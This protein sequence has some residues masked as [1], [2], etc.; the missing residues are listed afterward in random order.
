MPSAADPPF[1]GRHRLLE[2][3]AQGAMGE[4]YAARDE[5]RGRSVA[6]KR[7][8]PEALKIIGA[9]EHF[10]AEYRELCR[11]EHPRIIEV[12]D[13]GID[14]DQPFY[15]M[16]LLDGED[17][18][19]LAPMPYREA[20]RCLRDVASSLA[21][22]HARRLLHRDLS[23]R[24]VRRT[25]DG[26]CKLL[27]FGTMAPFGEPHN[28]AGT[29]P[30]VPPEALE[31]EALD[32]RSDLYSLG[33]LAYW[34]LTGR[35]AHDVQVIDELPASWKKPPPR[36]RRF[37]PEIPPALDDLVLSLLEL[38]PMGRPSSA[39]EVIERLTAAGGLEVDDTLDVAAS[40]LAGARLVGREHAMANIERRIEQTRD[41]RGVAVRID[42]DAGV[43][44]SRLLREAVLMAQ[45]Q[46]MAV[47]HA[48]ARDCPDERALARQ[49]AAE[50]QGAAPNDAAEARLGLEPGLALLDSH[51]APGAP[52]TDGTE[53][54]ARA[55]N[56]VAEWF[57]RVSRQRPL[58]VAVDDL[59]RADEF[60]AAFVASLAI[61]A[62]GLPLLVLATTTRRATRDQPSAV[63]ALTTVAARVPLSSL[64]EAQTGELMRSIF[65]DVPQLQ[66]VTHW[67]FRNAHGN[68]ALC[69]ELTQHLI[70]R[71]VVRYVSGQWA[72]PDTDITEE[73]PGELREALAMRLR[74][75]SNDAQ[76]IARLVAING[77]SAPDHLLRAA[78]EL[79]ERR[80][81]EA[82]RE[83]EHEQVLRRSGE[84]WVLSLDAMREALELS[85]EE[86]ERR[87]LHARLA[88]ALLDDDDQQARLLAGWHLV[89]TVDELRGADI[90]ADLGPRL[91]REGLGAASATRAIE[92]ALEVY[93]RHG[94]P[95]AA[96]LGLRSHLIVGGYLV[97]PA[98]AH[99]YGA[100]TI[101]ALY[102]ASG[103][104][105][106]RRL[107][108]TLGAK[109]G[110]YLGAAWAS[111]RRIFVA[112]SQRPPHIV[113]AT[114]YFCR[115]T[116]ALVGVRAT[117][118]D[119]PGTRALAE[120]IL[121]L[122]RSGIPGATEVA[123]TCQ[124]LAL[125]PWGRESEL[126][127]ALS[128]A[129]E[130]LDRL[131]VALVPGMTEAD[132]LDMRVGLWLSRGI[133]A[134]YRPGREG[135]EVA[136]RVEAMG[137]QLSGVCAD[138]IRTV[139]YTVRGYREEADRY[140][141]RIEM[142]AVQ[143]GSTWQVHAFSVPIEGISAA[144]YGDVVGA[145]RALERIDE[146]AERTP[147]LQPLR[148]LC[149]SAYQYARGQYEEV[150]RLGEAW[151][152]RH[153]PGTVIGWAQA[154][155]AHAGALL[156]LGRAEEARDMAERGL[157]AVPPDDLDYF[158]M[159]MPL[160]GIYALAVGMSGDET[161]SRALL[162]RLE[163]RLRDA[164]EHSALA[165]LS[166]YRT[167]MARKRHDQA[168][169]QA[170]LQSLEEAARLSRNPA[171]IA[172]AERIAGLSA[173]MTIGSDPPTA[174]GFAP[175]RV[176]LRDVDSGLSGK[177]E[178]TIVTRVLMDCRR[179][180][181][182]A[183][184]A[185]RL[186]AQYAGASRGYLLVTDGSRPRVAASLSREQP[187]EALERHVSDLIARGRGGVQVRI[188][189]D[190][191]DD[192]ACRVFGVFLLP[193][194]DDGCVGAVALEEQGEPL[195]RVRNELLREVGA[196]LV[197]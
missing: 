156:A 112:R 65:G 27:D 163:L 188:R 17:L 44:K 81:D 117:G 187:P 162:S 194:E 146:L 4:V 181:Q 11:L 84:R 32:Q 40:Y 79:S 169:L 25:G 160:Q 151:Q 102:R 42:G 100:E 182:R 26:R 143:G 91:M 147:S 58:L 189:A 43:G 186:L 190:D 114:H 111:V 107:A 69:V 129:I 120:L 48:S 127:R 2:R 55:Q 41:E 173:R 87:S 195:E 30:F 83:L 158:I 153:P 75:L 54:R 135:L 142:H 121:P 99:R 68:P 49:L 31:G 7:M 89:H 185:L 105:V 60:S 62:A 33:A 101:D 20:C 152:A 92:K 94:R 5:V 73:V 66:R 164:G 36:T 168:E 90:L 115:A 1:D 183:R 108:R 148:D 51:P 179:G 45:L 172:H 97:D 138:R 71:G 124:A 191:G 78:T 37:V 137:S 63:G 130:R 21:L 93:E 155:M 110:I 22:L 38:S 177:A 9:V 116:M 184:Q 180:D 29:P 82:L 95:L 122:A 88:A 12:Y 126:E 196:T 141:Q 193:D 19:Q 174:P 13:Y 104:D 170:S 34:L 23:P 8:R 161:R 86:H 178:Q 159:Y 59:D 53:A 145:R 103:L 76:G 24:N 80:A 175:A 70:E 72:L 192:G 98:I 109:L 61:A 39:S 10:R 56:A 106:A 139:Y 166:E 119:A 128:E 77:G 35:H 15:T 133:N 132:V 16:E 154:Y 46:G 157:D 125:Q 3:I 47:V 149:L 144:I 167:R 74:R 150:V 118:L 28:I 176:E 131:P 50:L 18:R 136:D 52:G 171:L 140:R 57:A 197:P 123:L 6:L 96:R 113:A 134:C 14:G 85:M 165:L 64:D 67:M